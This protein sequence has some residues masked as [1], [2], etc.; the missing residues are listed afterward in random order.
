MEF[1]HKS[2]PYYEWVDYGSKYQ[3][4]EL[5]AAVLIETELDPLAA[6]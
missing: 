3:M 6:I 4:N 1:E 2:A 5:N